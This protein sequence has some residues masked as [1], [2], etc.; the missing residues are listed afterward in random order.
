[1]DTAFGF[2]N[3]R[4]IGSS[5]MNGH[6]RT[7]TKRKWIRGYTMDAIQAKNTMHILYQPQM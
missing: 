5:V 3:A 1:M 6:M 7:E 4:T 2:A